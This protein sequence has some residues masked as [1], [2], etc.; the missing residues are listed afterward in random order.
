MN[1]V[2]ARSVSDE[3]SSPGLQMALSSLRL[4]GTFLPHMCVHACVCECVCVC[5]CV[6]RVKE[7][8]SLSVR[9]PVLPE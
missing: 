9:T 7:L 8:A 2:L 3:A 6:C 5:V 4:H 1:K